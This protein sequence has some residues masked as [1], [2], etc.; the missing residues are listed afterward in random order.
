MDVCI[1]VFYSAKEINGGGAWTQLP[2]P[3]SALPL[4]ED[5][6][7]VREIAP[8]IYCP[9]RLNNKKKIQKISFHVYSV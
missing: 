9:G 2:P 7:G 1:L 4:Y 5:T 6:V 3:I 8:Y